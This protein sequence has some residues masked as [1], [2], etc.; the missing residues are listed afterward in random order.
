MPKDKLAM[1]AAFNVLHREQKRKYTGEPYATHL[2]QV[3]GLAGCAEYPFGSPSLA[4]ISATAW[5]HDAM[6]DAGVSYD[7]LVFNFGETVA[8]G[9]RWLS[10]M[11]EGNRKERKK[12]A[13]E[14]LA[15][16]PAWVQTIKVADIISNTSSIRIHD[17][18]FA[19]VYLKEVRDLLE[20][21]TE[22]DEHLVVRA[23]LELNE[24]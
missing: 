6:E 2:A 1:L 14:R 11:E 19:K 5:L 22:A 20:V 24:K 4:D 17:P 10:D 16:A 12:L 23:R 18:K 21:L 7:A 13:R 9:V 3:A 8:D 15:K